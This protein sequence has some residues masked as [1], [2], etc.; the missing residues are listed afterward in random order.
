M[1]TT[2]GGGYHRIY[3]NGKRRFTH[4]VV[5]EEAY[6]PIPAGFHVHHKDFDAGNNELSNLQLLTPLEHRRLH[7]DYIT[8]DIGWAKKCKTCLQVFPVTEEH[9]Y[10]ARNGP[11]SSNC[12]SCQRQAIKDRKKRGQIDSDRNLPEAA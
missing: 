2:H 9:W 5:Y 10:F 6:G 3:Q 11:N 4:D 7:A 1:G 8:V 12:K